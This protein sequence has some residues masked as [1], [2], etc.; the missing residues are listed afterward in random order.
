MDLQLAE[1]LAKEHM[2]IWLPDS[3]W[4]FAWTSAF[5]MAGVCDW[6]NTQIRLSREFTEVQTR[7]DVE[8]TILHEIA[9]ALTGPMRD[10]HGW[11]WREQCRKVGARPMTCVDKNSA[12][13]GK[14]WLG[15]CPV[16]KTVGDTRQE[17]GKQFLAKGRWG[18]C[19]RCSSTYDERFKLVWVDRRTLG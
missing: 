1:N 19:G 4:T 18:S 13:P 5:S 11:R 17:L 12:Q 3:R 15:V 2:A 16:C 9:H 8:D 14:R 10:A 7:V 6:A